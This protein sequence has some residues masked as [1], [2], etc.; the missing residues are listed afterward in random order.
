VWI[1]PLAGDF[2][3]PIFLIFIAV[4][5]MLT[6]ISPLR[7]KKQRSSHPLAQLRQ[8]L[9]QRIL[10]SK[11]TTR[12]SVISVDIAHVTKNRITCL[13]RRRS[14]ARRNFDNSSLMIS[15]TRSADYLNKPHLILFKS[16]ITYDSL[17][18]NLKNH[19]A[20]QARNTEALTPQYAIFFA[21]N[22]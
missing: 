19:H 3:Y 1:I 12:Q 8:P 18:Y 20:G 4:L 11:S 21:H 2:F 10:Q 7:S 6:L 17:L 15:I 5:G 9:H 14:S 13:R 16:I 22:T